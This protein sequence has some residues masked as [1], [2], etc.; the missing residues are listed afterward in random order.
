MGTPAFAVPALEA[1]CA[2]RHEVRAVITAPDKPR[3]RGRKTFPSEV[4]Q[5][6]V[7]LDIPVLTRKLRDPSFIAALKRFSGGY[8]CR[9]CLS[10]TTSGIRYSS[11]RDHQCTSYAFAEIPGGTPHSLG[12][13]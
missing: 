13:L 7:E 4:K 1:L 9:C 11:L 12:G 8:F 6:A 10:D 2:S 3:G 5:K